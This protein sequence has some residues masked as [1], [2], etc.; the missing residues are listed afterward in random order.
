MVI[1]TP[2][3]HPLASQDQVS[4][5]ELEHFP[6]IGYDRKSGLGGYT[7]RL[8]RSLDMKPDILCECADENAIQALVREGFGIALVADVDALNRNDIRILKLSDADLTHTINMVWLKNHYQM[9]DVKCFID[10]M[11]NRSDIVK[12]HI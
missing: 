9:P 6:V 8:Y 10:F 7:S 2:I 1:I 4:I 3:D 5:N 12:D 11:K